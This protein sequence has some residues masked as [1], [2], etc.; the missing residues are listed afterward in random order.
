M[1]VCIEVGLDEGDAE[2][3]RVAIAKLPLQVSIH[4]R[5]WPWSRTTSLLISADGGCACSMFGDADEL[6]AEHR[7]S[8]A[9]VVEGLDGCLF[10]EKTLRA[11]WVGDKPTAELALTASDL[12]NRIREGTFRQGIA[13][14]VSWR[15]RAA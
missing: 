9:T 13:Y 11:D 8:L 15:G 3:V 6:L 1:C 5:G 10:G 14:R 4:G 12:A 7:E 2:R